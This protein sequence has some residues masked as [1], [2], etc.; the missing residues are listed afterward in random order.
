MARIASGCACISGIKRYFNER[1]WVAKSSKK[2]WS[3]EGQVE[4]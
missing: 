2:V 1:A 3:A 4:L